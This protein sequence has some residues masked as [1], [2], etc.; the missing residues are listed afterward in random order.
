[1]APQKN[2]PIPFE[3]VD[4]EALDLK[5]LIA[6]RIKVEALIKQRQTQHK[7]NFKQ[8]INKK[9]SSLG[10]DLKEYFETPFPTTKKPYKSKLKAKYEY[11]GVKWSGRGRCPNIFQLY[12]DNG[13]KKEDLLIDKKDK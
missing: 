2:K 8:K 5:T 4:I 10:I 12:F 1:M 7:K 6:I 13:G 11:Q 3:D 9:A